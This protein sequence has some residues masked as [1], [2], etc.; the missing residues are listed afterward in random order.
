MVDIQVSANS[1]NIS[2]LIFQKLAEFNLAVENLFF[3]CDGAAVN[4]KISNDTGISTFLCLNHG[5]HLAIVDV[6][7]SNEEKYAVVDDSD[8]TFLKIDPIKPIFRFLSIGLAE[9]ICGKQSKNLLNCPN[10][11]THSLKK[12]A[13]ELS[14]M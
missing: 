12:L 7:Y 4:K 1:A 3:T 13:K 14:S 11:Q 5:L 6:L 8:A 10:F 2:N 9:K